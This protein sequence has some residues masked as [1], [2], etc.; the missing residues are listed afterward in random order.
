[1]NMGLTRW[2]P[3]RTTRLF[4]LA[5]SDFGVPSLF[6]D[7][8]RMSSPVAGWD[9]NDALA[10]STWMPP[11]DIADDANQIV[12]TAELPGFK[13]GDVKVELHGDVLSLSG[14][15]KRESENK[16]R[17]YTRVE[18]SYGQFTRSFTLPSI[19]DREKVKASFAEGLLTIE[20]P[21]KP[22]AKPRQIPIGNG[23]GKKEQKAIAG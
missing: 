21:K 19:V 23:K 13:E 12:V 4:P 6:R 17:N 18:R 7:F 2:E 10:S 8:L 20:L 3:F 9:E 5:G 22:E 15:R 14:E 1:M 16:E 11:V